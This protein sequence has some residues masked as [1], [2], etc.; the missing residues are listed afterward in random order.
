MK[1]PFSFGTRLVFRLV[2]PGLVSTVALFSVI[3]YV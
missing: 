3:R 1:L 2:L